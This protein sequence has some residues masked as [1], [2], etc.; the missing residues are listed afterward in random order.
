MPIIERDVVFQGVDEDGNATIDMPI[1]RLGNLEDT[2]AVKESL[3]DEDYIPVIDSAGNWQMKKAKVAA[4]KNALK[5]GDVTMEQVNEAIR[6][7][8]AGALEEA[9]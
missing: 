7:A 3:A 1:T 6:I 5:N 2:A 4:L 8:I 9:Y